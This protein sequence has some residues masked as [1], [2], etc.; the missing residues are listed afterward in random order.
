MSN[1]RKDA[2]G[3]FRISSEFQNRYLRY[4]PSNSANK[5]TGAR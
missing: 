4:Y 2:E 3:V 5:L 1:S